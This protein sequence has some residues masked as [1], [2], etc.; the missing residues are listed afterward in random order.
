MAVASRSGEMC[1][2]SSTLTLASVFSGKEDVRGIKD[3]YPDI[4]SEYFWRGN[5]AVNVLLHIEK[6]PKP[7]PREARTFPYHKKQ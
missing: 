2:N 6:M 3:T 7:L 5:V 1:V 4:S